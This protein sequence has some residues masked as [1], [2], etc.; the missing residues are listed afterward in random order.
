[1]KRRI[2]IIIA[3]M[4]FATSLCSCNNDKG[5]NGKESSNKD[6]SISTVNTIK[7]YASYGELNYADASRKAV[8]VMINDISGALANR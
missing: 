4:I 7:A 6:D 1:M 8:E 5:K 3:S 2:L